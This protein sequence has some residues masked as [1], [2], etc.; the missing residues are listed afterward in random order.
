VPYASVVRVVYG[1][2]YGNWDDPVIEYESEDQARGV[3]IALGFPGVVVVKNILETDW[4]VV[5]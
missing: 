3:L 4:E 5:L 1:I 2:V